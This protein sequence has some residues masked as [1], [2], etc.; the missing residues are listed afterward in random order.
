MCRL[1]EAE[2]GA[3]LPGQRTEP[4][5]SHPQKVFLQVLGVTPRV[6]SFQPVALLERRGVSVVAQL[7]SGV[8][9][10]CRAQPSQPG[11][12]LSHC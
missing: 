7:P 9:H 8:D 10:P 6:G 11:V 3:L 5:Q 12:E 1:R 4:N 2:A